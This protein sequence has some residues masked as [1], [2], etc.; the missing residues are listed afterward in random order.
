[1]AEG[2][3]HA[4]FGVLGML[5]GA[6]AYAEVYAPIKSTILTWGDYGKISLVDL[7]GLPAGV[8]LAVMAGLVIGL[9]AMIERW[10]RGGT[11]PAKPASSAG[12]ERSTAVKSRVAPMAAI[13]LAILISSA[14]A[15]AEGGPGPRGDGPGRGRGPRHGQLD[16][17]FQADREMFRFL[18][19]N[20]EKIRREVRELEGGVETVTV[21]DDP[22]VASYIRKHVA[23]MYRRVEDGRPIHRRDPLFAE[24]FRHA[25]E[26]KL[27]VE[28]TDGGIRPGFHDILYASQE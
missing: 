11:P 1:M 8:I 6:A 18:L 20:H 15:F 26:I 9:F 14:D 12:D 16:T 3:R 22:K 28:E 25:D 19:A 7:T 10:E 23:A 13:L 24:L 27:K 4:I 21:S 5:F 2:S 17:E